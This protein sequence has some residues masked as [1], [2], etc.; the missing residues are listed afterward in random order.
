MS[1]GGASKKR[2]F[3]SPKRIHE[4]VWDSGSEETAA[5]SDSTSE[6]EG[7]FQDAPGVH[8][9]NLTT[10]HPVVKLPA[11]RYQQVPLMVF[12]LGQV[13][14]GHGP[15]RGVGGKERVKRCI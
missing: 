15:Q 14:S 10:R 3:L 1:G 12:R 5:S 7:G 11:V 8:T 2:R 13:S 6:K 4:L 9:C